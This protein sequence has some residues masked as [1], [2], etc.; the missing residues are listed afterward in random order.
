[1]M[2]FSLLLDSFIH[3]RTRVCRICYRLQFWLKLFSLRATSHQV[4][5]DWPAKHSKQLKQ[6]AKIMEWYFCSTEMEKFWTSE[7]QEN[8]KNNKKPKPFSL[9]WSNSLTNSLQQYVFI[10]EILPYTWRLIHFLSVLIRVK[11]NF[12]CILR[13]SLFN[14]TCTTEKTVWP[15]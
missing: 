5:E 9:F 2:N 13:S 7:N 10:T 12:M 3:W 6:M 11:Y 14:S 4:D 15:L 8:N 1:M